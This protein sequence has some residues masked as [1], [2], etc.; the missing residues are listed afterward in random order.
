MEAVAGEHIRAARETEL[1]EILRE[2]AAL[3]AAI[4]S[5]WTERGLPFDVAYYKATC[6]LAGRLTVA[7]RTVEEI[8]KMSP[9]STDRSQF[10]LFISWMTGAIRTPEEIAAYLENQE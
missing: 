7:I 2:S 8:K 5:A 6:A 4:V 1:K 9:E 10:G 3:L